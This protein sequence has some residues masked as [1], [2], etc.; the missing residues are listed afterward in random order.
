M[1]VQARFE[2]EKQPTPSLLHRR[3][4]TGMPP[5]LLSALPVQGTKAPVPGVPGAFTVDPLLSPEECAA[6]VAAAD[7]LG[8]APLDAEF[9]PTERNNSRVM[10]LD[11]ELALRLYQRLLPHLAVTDVVFVKP[12]G[13]GNEGCWR[14]TRLNECLKISRYHEAERF[15]PHMDGPW[16]PRDDESS[17]LTLVVYLNTVA[18]GGATTFYA[19]AQDAPVATVT[20]TVG[21]ALLF[22]HDTLHGAAPVGPDCAKFVLRTEVMFARFNTPDI[23]PD[24]L[25]AYQRDPAYLL[26]VTVY[27]ASQA[28]FER[29][30]VADFTALY[31]EATEIQVKLI[32]ALRDDALTFLFL[33]RAA[34]ARPAAAQAYGMRRIPFPV[35]V[36]VMIFCY[37]Y[38]DASFVLLSP[39]SRTLAA[40]RHL[41]PPPRCFAGLT[42]VSRTLL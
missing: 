29:G 16:I 41:H 25:C 21:K 37:L 15:A 24:A 2:Q 36:C 17:I 5:S 27:A 33:K 18:A 31:K 35:D 7:G 26:M 20:P 1:R 6:V 30:D 39:P 32:C 19:E 9:S 13:F 42:S 40:Q 34:S 12:V 23:P 38:C 22:F 3:P 10:V 14:P 11:D 8:F 4:L 28:A